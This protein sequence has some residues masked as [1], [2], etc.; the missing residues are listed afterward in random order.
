MN[1]G[2]ATERDEK[3]FNQDYEK[4]VRDMFDVMQISCEERYKATCCKLVSV[5]FNDE[6]TFE[7]CPYAQKLLK[8]V[9]K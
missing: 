5:K 6:C 4:G 8:A 1:D 7:N 2:F 9:K 3:L